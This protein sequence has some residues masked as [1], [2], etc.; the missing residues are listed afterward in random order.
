MCHLYTC[1]AVYTHQTVQQK[2][3]TLANLTLTLTL[4]YFNPSTCCPDVMLKNTVRAFLTNQ[5]PLW[6]LGVS[7]TF[8]H[9]RECALSV[10]LNNSRLHHFWFDWSFLL[11]SLKMWP[12]LSRF[13]QNGTCG[14]MTRVLLKAKSLQAFCFPYTLYSKLET[15]SL[16]VACG[17]YPAETE[18][19]II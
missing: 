18:S 8:D 11:I 1:G 9:S 2:H 15:K 13:A 16:D 4:T 14:S 5:V 12:G 19:C 6:F 7:L 10:S 17:S 3:P